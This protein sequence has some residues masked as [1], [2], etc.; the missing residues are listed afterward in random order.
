MF[1]CAFIVCMILPEWKSA[2]SIID[3]NHTI[4]KTYANEKIPF[5]T[6]IIMLFFCHIPDGPGG[7]RG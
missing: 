5:I 6:D 1:A 2:E 4:S 3:Q 7:R